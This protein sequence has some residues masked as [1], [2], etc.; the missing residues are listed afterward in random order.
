MGGRVQY[1]GHD[2]PSRPAVFRKQK[3]PD[4]CNPTPSR[5]FEERADTSAC[6]SALTDV[7]SY[8]P[9]RLWKIVEHLRERVCVSGSFHWGRLG[10]RGDPYYQLSIIR[11]DLLQ[12]TDYL[13][14][15]NANLNTSSAVLCHLMSNVFIFREF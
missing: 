6:R 11:P 3:L 7:L 4:I 10:F 5:Y 15:S 9:A 13:F 1:G 12:I 8:S 14:H 2:A